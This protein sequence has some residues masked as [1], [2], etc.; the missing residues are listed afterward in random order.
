MN[1]LIISHVFNQPGA[2][3]MP[4]FPWKII[5]LIIIMVVLTETSSGYPGDSGFRKEHILI[6][7]N[8]TLTDYPVLFILHRDSSG[9]DSGNEAY[10]GDR[11]LPDYSDIR[12]TL[13]DDTT[14]PHT[15]AS[16]TGDKADVFVTV[17]SIPAD[18]FLSLFLWYGT[19]SV[20]PG[21][22]STGAAADVTIRNGSERQDPVQSGFSHGPWE[23]G[24]G[25]NPAVTDVISPESVPLAIDDAYISK[26]G[27]IRTYYLGGDILYSG[28]EF[29]PI[30]IM[31]DNVL[32]DGN[33]YTITNNAPKKGGSWQFGVNAGS[34]KKIVRNITIRN[35][36]VSGWDVGISFQNVIGDGGN[37]IAEVSTSGSR[38]FG[39]GLE[40]S[41]DVTVQESRIHDSVAN[42][43][44]V[45]R[46]TGILF[47]N[48]DLKTA[49]YGIAYDD[50]RDIRVQNN[51]LEDFEEGL[52]VLSGDGG[53]MSGNTLQK[54]KQNAITLQKS[55]NILVSDNR[56]SD[57]VIGIEMEG[58]SDITLLNNTLAS[59]GQDSVWVSVSDGITASGNRIESGMGGISLT[60]VKNS[61]IAH[62]LIE[63][64][65]SIAIC[66]NDCASSL[67][68]TNSI[69]HAGN[70]INVARGKDINVL[71]SPRIEMVKSVG[72]TY[73][74]VENGEISN[75]NIKSSENVGI[76]LI[77]SSAIVVSHNLI[78]NTTHSGIYVES[79][80]N[81]RFEKNLLSK[82]S[83]GINLIK[84]T[85][86]VI[87]GNKFMNIE[88]DPV[89]A[90]KDSHV[91]SDMS[92]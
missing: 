56:M 53:E 80:K 81:S 55:R 75:N 44:N 39:I 48:N 92:T 21:N 10:L 2:G 26:N 47:R 66:L 79:V 9:T 77:S 46:S 54:I 45:R 89:F 57:S 11:S 67:I 35:V 59:H 8:E 42:G 58:S 20:S 84:T 43:A 30:N 74:S 34:P 86:S 14:L 90:D 27:G 78:E 41:T 36:K 73:N 13:E 61:T 72:I 22:T 5:I 24:G 68:D 15:I 52:S 63:D 37:M 31:V 70:G 28:D 76:G 51:Q 87:S 19:G 25:K 23:E 71:N 91:D 3:I 49:R 1:N 32:L 38:Q 62:N 4:V 16:F 85:S 64:V 82:V 40:N 83:T 17:P 69:I 88:F 18:D 33:N 50:C 7:G 29:S 12:F 6:G 65:Q 60:N